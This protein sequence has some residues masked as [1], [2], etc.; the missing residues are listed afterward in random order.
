MLRLVA[1]A[2]LALGALL[3]PAP[4]AD[5][6]YVVPLATAK[7]AASLLRLSDTAVAFCAPCGDAAPRPVPVVTVGIDPWEGDPT[8]WVVVLNGEGVDLAYLYLPLHGDGQA[9]NLARLTFPPGATQV[10]STIDWP[11]GR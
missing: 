3:S 10:P 9:V 4:A 5:Q 7:A 6:A 11:A 2:P 8:Q 1:L